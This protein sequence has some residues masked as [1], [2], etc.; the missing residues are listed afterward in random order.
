MAKYYKPEEMYT[1]LVNLGIQEKHG[2]INTQEA[3]KVLTWRA[4]AE[5]D[6]DN[7]YNVNAVRKRVATGA[8][9]PVGGVRQNSRYNTYK[10]ED[11]FTLP[12]FPTRGIQP[13]REKTAS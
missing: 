11:V 1:A 7:E 5:Y 8:L 2:T 10:I 6:V 12:I 4:K 13:K 3:A 9:V